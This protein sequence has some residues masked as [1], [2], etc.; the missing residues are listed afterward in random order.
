MSYDTCFV[1]VPSLTK[2]K[3]LWGTV[4]GNRKGMPPLSQ[5][6]AAGEVQSVTSDSLMAIKWCDR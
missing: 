5:K 1:P 2:E 4:C 6:L 3:L